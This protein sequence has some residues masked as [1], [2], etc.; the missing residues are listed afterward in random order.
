[1]ANPCITLQYCVKTRQC[2]GMRHSVSSLRLNQ[3]LLQPKRPIWMWLTTDNKQLCH[4]NC[5]PTASHYTDISCNVC[6]V[7]KITAMS[8][9]IRESRPIC[10]DS[11][12]PATNCCISS[13]LASWQDNQTQASKLR[14]E[15]I[16]GSILHF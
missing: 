1:M 6:I 16:A 9:R 5:R 13:W 11:L 10:A 7:L 15:G 2:R 3:S 4:C 14:V 8:R 12:I